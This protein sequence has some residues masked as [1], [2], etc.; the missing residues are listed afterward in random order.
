M[1]KDLEQLTTASNFNFSATK[2]DKLGAS[3]YTLAVIACDASGSVAPFATQLETMLKTVRKACD[4]SDRRDNLMLRLTQFASSVKELHGFKLLNTVKEDDYNSILNVGGSTALYAAALEA[5][6]SATLYGKQLMA[7][8]ILTNAIV[9]VVTDGEENASG[10]IVV[11]DIK[12]AVAD[13]GHQE[14]LESLTVVLVGVT[15]NQSGLSQYLHDFKDGAGITQY[16]DIGN[17]TPGR[18]AK[19]AQFVSSSISSTSSALG[20]GGP[21]KPTAFTI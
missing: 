4:K 17:A 10:G 7:Q 13:A 18:L 11:N 20:S 5:I 14:V 9:F 3:E 16:V 1:D 2:I 15:N 19:L 6:E 21:S 12:K 8:D